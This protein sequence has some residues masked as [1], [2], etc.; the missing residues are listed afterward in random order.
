MPAVAGVLLTG[1]R[2]TRLGT[3]KATLAVGGETLGRR[4]ARVLTTV[5]DPV[6]EVGPGVSGLPSSLEEPAGAG[7]LA[8]LCAGLDA[9]DALGTLDGFDAGDGGSTG[10][11]TSRNGLVLLAC[12]LPFV[13]EPL[14]RL[15]IERSPARSVVPVRAG[16]P[17]WTCARYAPDAL[18]AARAARREGCASLRDAMRATAVELVAEPEWQ[19][20]APP[21]ALDDVDTP[22]DLAR[23]LR[24]IGGGGGG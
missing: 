17:Q 8:A 15:L 21:H 6:L 18:A 4:A 14:L 19:R 16:V 20:I 11:G 12:D 24:R 5:C 1:G 9:L 13:E 2:S 23:F 7:P 22:A 3:D 10:T